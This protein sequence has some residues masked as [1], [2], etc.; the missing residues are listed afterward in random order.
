MNIIEAKDLL[1]GGKMVRRSSWHFGDT[2]I[3]K[4]VPSEIPKEVVPRMT[5]L[6]EAVKG[7]FQR[8]FESIQ[9]QANAIYYQNQLAIVSPSNQIEGYSFSVADFGATDWVEYKPE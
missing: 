5:S 6:P 3:F 4:Q 9:F 8:R 2:F 1:D 7:E